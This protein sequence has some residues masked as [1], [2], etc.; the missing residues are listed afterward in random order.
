LKL[1]C[2]AHESTLDQPLR[3]FPNKL[4]TAITG[5]VFE[6]LI[7][8]IICKLVLVP[9]NPFKVKF[10]TTC[11]EWMVEQTTS[12]ILV[13]LASG[14]A[15]LFWAWGCLRRLR[16]LRTIGELSL[17]NLFGIVQCRNTDCNSSPLEHFGCKVLQ[18]PFFLEVCAGSARV[19]WCLQHL[20]LL[21]WP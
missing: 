8:Q 1:L 18:D 13:R 20:G 6:I 5:K 7:N 3:V 17:E 15:I 10:T 2:F 11:V 14:W 21:F 4:H 19:T 12:Q 9:S 16:L